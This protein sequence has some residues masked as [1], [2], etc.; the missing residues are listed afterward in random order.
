[1]E[2]EEMTFGFRKSSRMTSEVQE[3]SCSLRQEYEESV[4]AMLTLKSLLDI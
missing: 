1:M 3:R 2:R 4:P